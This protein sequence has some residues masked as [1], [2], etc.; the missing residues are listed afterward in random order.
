MTTNA[1]ANV[2]D[3]GGD[4]GDNDSGSEGESDGGDGDSAW[5]D[6]SDE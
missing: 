5:S 6:L 4:D 3:L 1:K 2:S